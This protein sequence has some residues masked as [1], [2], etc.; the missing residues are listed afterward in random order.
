[1]TT[2]NKTSGTSVSVSTGAGPGTMK[3]AFR[4]RI[5]SGGDRSKVPYKHEVIDVSHQNSFIRV[6]KGKRY[7]VIKYK[8]RYLKRRVRP[9][10][11]ARGEDVPHDYTTN[12]IVQTDP[13]FEF[14]QLGAAFRTCTG[15][16]SGFGLPVVSFLWD[17]NDDIAALGKLREKIAGSDFNAGVA[18]GESREALSMITNSATRVYKSYRAA[19]I[20][21][22]RNASRFLVEGTDRRRLGRK[23]V[24]SNWLELQYGW[25]PLLKDAEGAAQFLA[26]T[27]EFPLRQ[28]Y[29]IRSSKRQ[30]T[31]RT[32]SPASKF[33]DS[34][35]Y[36]R[37]AIVAYLQEKDV[38]KLSGLL[39]PLSV[40]WE[41]TPYSFVID[42]FIPIGNYLAARGLSQSLTGT[43]VTT[44]KDYAR[45]ANIVSARADTVLRGSGSYSYERIALTRTVSTTL[46][47][48]TP[49]IKPLGDVS[50]W[51]RAA[52]A[53]ALL[54]QLR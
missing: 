15:D 5:W 22:F 30:G 21:D 48:P 42:W 13:V 10:A 35:C 50:S 17:S 43:F 26:E 36:S 33:S 9:T 20:G 3:L 44:R 37:K 40:A 51:K 27:F 14:S 2:G 53:V 31:I 12:V 25:L 7:V 16:N 29:A 8:Q 19:R 24:S 23:S 54:S 52:N 47:V 45:G 32:S 11:R 38:V 18:L 4:Q 46:S 49:T 28:R 6:R 39:D 1:V 41:L 34:E